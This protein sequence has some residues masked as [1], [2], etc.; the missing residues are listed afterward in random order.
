MRQ[1]EQTPPIR[2]GD[3]T[4]REQFGE[5]WQDYESIRAL[6][7]TRRVDGDR[8]PNIWIQLQVS[9]NGSKRTGLNTPGS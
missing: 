2:L 3:L 8:W 4:Q 9:R 6:V 7:R 1:L 5:E